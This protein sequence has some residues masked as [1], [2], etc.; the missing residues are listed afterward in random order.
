MSVSLV[1]GLAALT[2]CPLFVSG[3]DFNGARRL[4]SLRD[5]GAQVL[6][7]YH[8]TTRELQMVRNLPITEDDG[9]RQV[10]GKGTRLFNKIT[11]DID[12]DNFKTLI[13]AG[14]THADKSD[15]YC[16]V[17]RFCDSCSSD[18]HV[19]IYYKRISPIPKNTNFLDVFLNDWSDKPDNLM[20]VDFELYSTYEDAIRGENQWTFC[21]YSSGTGTGFPRDCGPNG[22][23]DNQWNSYVKE[24]GA[25]GD[26]GFYVEMPKLGSSALTH[27]NQH[28]MRL[29]RKQVQEERGR[30]M[31]H[32]ELLAALGREPTYD[33]FN[34]SLN[35][36]LPETMR[37]IRRRGGHLANDSYAEKR[38]RSAKYVNLRKELREKRRAARNARHGY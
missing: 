31:L 2:L 11:K 32:A 30:N 28:G 29:T 23:V 14:C 18:D 7:D 22:K 19:D 1:L 25:A 13:R 9:W 35:R 5:D 6:V 20:H 37:A 8:D 26:H 33:E 16:I 12:G 15:R 38:W 10:V 34:S 24:G 27:T 21:N 4:M 3:S 17:R 36:G